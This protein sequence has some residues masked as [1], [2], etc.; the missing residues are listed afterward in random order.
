MSEVKLEFELYC[1]EAST[2][3]AAYHIE[4]SI[5]NRLGLSEYPCACNRCRGARLQKTEVVARHHVQ[6]GRDPYLQYPVIVS[7]V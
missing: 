2:M 3:T 1:R 5:A 4:Q 6:N 7:A